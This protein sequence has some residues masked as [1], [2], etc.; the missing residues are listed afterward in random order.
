MC[1]IQPTMFCL[2]LILNHFPVFTL[3]RRRTTPSR[4]SHL[5]LP[6]TPMQPIRKCRGRASCDG[7]IKKIE[8]TKSLQIKLKPKNNQKSVCY[9]SLTSPH[10]LSSS[11][12]TTILTCRPSFLPPSPPVSSSNMS[13]RKTTLHVISPL[14]VLHIKTFHC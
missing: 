9:I 12:L 2:Y 3:K 6:L 1:Q 10:L 14:S 7:K 8:Y 5:V 11:K 4:T 13:D